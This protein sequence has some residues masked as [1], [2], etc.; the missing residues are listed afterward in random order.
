MGALPAQSLLWAQAKNS[1]VSY[2]RTYVVWHAR[3]PVYWPLVFIPLFIIYPSAEC[4]GTRHAC[5]QADN[6]DSYTWT[7]Y[8]PREGGV[9]VIRDSANN[10]KITTEFL[11]VSGGDHG[12]SWAARVKG[13]PITPGSR[14]QLITPAYLL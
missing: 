12:G 9:Q 14:V 11:K 3:L 6:L 7:E 8:D 1:T 4:S 10:V 13:E 5:D 2:D